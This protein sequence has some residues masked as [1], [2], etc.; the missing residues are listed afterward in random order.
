MLDGNGHDKT[1]DWW[2]LGIIVYELLSGIPP[3]YDKDQSV[4]F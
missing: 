1:L 3:Y 4:M 2:A